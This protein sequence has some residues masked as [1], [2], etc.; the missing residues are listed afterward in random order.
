MTDEVTAHGPIVWHEGGT[1]AVRSVQG[2][3]VVLRS[4]VP[5]PPG[6]PAQGTLHTASGTHAFTV[7]VV[8]SQKVA[9]GVWDVRGR[10]VSATTAV[11]AA[12]AAMV[13]T[14]TAGA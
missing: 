8:R 5:Y 12:F 2:V 11:R 6:K 14:A 4:S 1:A 7:K 10:L 13:C 3:D 9:E